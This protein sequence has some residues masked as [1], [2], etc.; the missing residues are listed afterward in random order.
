MK[1][2]TVSTLTHLMFLLGAVT[3]P[4]A[5]RKGMAATVASASFPLP[6]LGEIISITVGLAVLIA[7]TVIE[8]KM[9]PKKALRPQPLVPQIAE[10]KGS[11]ELVEPVAEKSA[12]ETPYTTESAETVSNN[13]QKKATVCPRCQESLPDRPLKFCPFCGFRFSE[14]KEEKPSA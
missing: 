1:K 3:M 13:I 10:K 11:E 4:V 14:Q 12:A 9:H 7:V 2:I 8:H 5:A 6:T